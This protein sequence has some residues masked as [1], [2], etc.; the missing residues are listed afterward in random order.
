MKSI[1]MTIV[2]VI[3]AFAGDNLAKYDISMKMLG[4]I[5]KSTLTISTTEDTYK[6]KMHLQ[7]DKSLSDVEHS[8]ES[9]GTIVDGVYKPERFVKYIRE[10]EDEI[11]N[12]YI[13]DYEKQQIQKYTTEKRSKSLLGGLFSSDDKVV[14]ESFELLTDFTPNDT[15]TTFLNAERLLAGRSEMVVTSVGFRKDER[16]ISLH[17]F[18]DEYRVKVVDKEEND[19]YSIM[20]AVSPDGMVRKILIQEYTMLGTIDVARNQYTD[21]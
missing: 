2:L 19:D 10:G 18:K 20:V 8:Y 7:M 6:I 4:E 5:G 13:F 16:N 14:T 9:Y 15:M 12:Y 21:K 11:T 17:R 3:T 1:L